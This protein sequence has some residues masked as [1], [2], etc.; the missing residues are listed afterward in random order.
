[1]SLLTVEEFLQQSIQE[2]QDPE[3]IEVTSFEIR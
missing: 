1:M 3:V 2:K